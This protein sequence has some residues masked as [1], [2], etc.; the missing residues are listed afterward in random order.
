MTKVVY[1]PFFFFN[2]RKIVS[3]Y[4]DFTNMDVDDKLKKYEEYNSEIDLAKPLPVDYLNYSPLTQTAKPEIQNT[5]LYTPAPLVTKYIPQTE[6]EFVKSDRVQGLVNAKIDYKPEGKVDV[7][8]V[9]VKKYDTISNVIDKMPD[10]KKITKSQKEI[11]DSIDNTGYDSDVK[12]Y[13]KLLAY[14]ESRFDPNV[15]NKYNYKGLYQFG[16]KALE[17]TKTKVKDYISDIN[18]QHAAAVELR[19]LNTIGLDKYIG[20]TFGGITMT[21]N[22][23]AAAAH[24][25]GR[26]N[27]MKFINSNGKN[28]FK[29]GKEGDKYRTPISHY[30]KVFSK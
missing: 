4:M 17:W 11:L 1:P 16:N 10:L 7:K 23:M 12:D 21:K 5:A 19:R 8:K 29:D 26:G 2:L 14:K 6:V 25:G 27:L 9:D 30:L 24:L 13:L 28:D 20:K 3:L 15:I 22:N 18:V